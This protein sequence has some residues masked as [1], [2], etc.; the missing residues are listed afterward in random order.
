[1][2]ITGSRKPSCPGWKKV[3]GKEESDLDRKAASALGRRF[4]QRRGLPTGLWP[5]LLPRVPGVAGKSHTRPASRPECLCPFCLQSTCSPVPASLIT[6]FHPSDVVGWPFP[7][8]AAYK[9][10]AYVLFSLCRF[11]VALTRPC[12]W[13]PGDGPCHHCPAPLS[14]APDARRRGPILHG[15]WLSESAPQVRTGN[16]EGSWF[17]FSFK[18]LTG[19]SAQFGNISLNLG[20]ALGDT[21]SCLIDWGI[22]LPDKWW[23]QK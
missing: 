6:S 20:R 13:F 21:T 1:M 17:V 10:S 11:R 8:G 23:F 9:R 3:P 18:G 14:A 4:T 12:P 19:E 16:S 7:R 15:E 5:H 22:S 2:G